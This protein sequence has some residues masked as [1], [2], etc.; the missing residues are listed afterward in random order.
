MTAALEEG[1]RFSDA[2]KWPLPTFLI[3]G[4]MRSGTTSLARYLGAHPEVYV[5]SEKELHYFD[6][7]FSKG[8]DWYRKRFRKARSERAIGEATQTYMYDEVS[9][10][11]MAKTLP[12]LKLIAILRDPVDRAYSHFQLNRSL[13]I[14]P[15]AFELALEQETARLRS[16]DRRQR[17]AYSYIDRGR[18]LT[19]LT[20]L[21]NHY[22]RDS[23][24][25]EVLE[26]LRKDPARAYRSLC[27][28]LEVDPTFIPSTL[29]R[30]ANQH[31]TF[32]YQRIRRLSKRLPRTMTGPIGRLNRRGSAYE[33]LDQ[34]ARNH[35]MSSYFRG[36]V[37]AL[38]D[39]LGREFP[40]WT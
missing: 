27:Q 35:V 6:R 1:L 8:L 31:V 24:H 12:N 26:D 29:G 14:E 9:I 23:L 28:F 17:F 40:D 18:Y 19:Q 25:V 37:N 2:T 10:E 7:N 33:P 30:I 16:P 32:R 20:R 22:P 38:S 13:G 11:R 4:A 36:E 5:P 39:W 15:L 21:C 3:V 34:V